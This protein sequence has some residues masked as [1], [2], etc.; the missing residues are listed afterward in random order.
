M[1]RSKKRI[2]KSFIDFDNKKQINFDKSALI[3]RLKADFNFS[4]Q[5]IRLIFFFFFEKKKMIPLDDCL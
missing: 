2:E 4:I 1:I 3:P 5:L